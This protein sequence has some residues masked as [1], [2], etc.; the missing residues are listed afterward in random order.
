MRNK[1][2]IWVF[3]ILNRFWQEQ[4]QEQH[5]GPFFFLFWFSYAA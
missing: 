3:Q 5:F 4:I 2:I 1:S